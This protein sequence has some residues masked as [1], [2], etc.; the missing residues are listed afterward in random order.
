MGYIA[1]ECFCFVVSRSDR[2][3]TSYA[4]AIPIAHH[5]NK[6]FIHSHTK[7]QQQQKTVA[8]MYLINHSLP[9]YYLYF[10]LIEKPPPSRW[11]S[12]A[13]T[14]GSSGVRRSRTKVSQRAHG[15][16]ASQYAPYVHT[17]TDAPTH[18]SVYCVSAYAS[19]A[20]VTVFASHTI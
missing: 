3:H 10:M 11:S 13:R 7:W 16:L 1:W 20:S 5:T 15:L 14:P 9:F 18:M 17:H 19:V 6:T 2:L 8:E 12:R 4:R